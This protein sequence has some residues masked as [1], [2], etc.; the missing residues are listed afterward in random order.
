MGNPIL[1]Q[2]CLRLEEK[3]IPSSLSIGKK[4]RF[5]KEGHRLYQLNVPMD[6]R[7]SDWKFIARIVITEY[8]LGNEKTEGIFVV[9]KQFTDEEKKIITKTYISDEEVEQIL[10]KI[11]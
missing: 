11:S 7:T 8:T 1:L 5:C 4:Y 9:V 6:L 2:A 10:K 3:V